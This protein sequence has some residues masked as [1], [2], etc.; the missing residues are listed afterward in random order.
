[1]DE[2]LAQLPESAPERSALLFEHGT[3]T[4][5]IY[6]ARE[7]DRQTPHERDEVYV[8]IRGK[9]EFV[10]G[11]ERRA[12]KEHDF[13]FVRAGARNIASRIFPTI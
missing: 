9:G 11:D 5:K 13:I 4:V 12:I 8:V 3:L 1:M 7:I 6:G 10:C 2:A